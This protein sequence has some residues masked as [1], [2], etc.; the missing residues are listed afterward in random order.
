MKYTQT[1]MSKAVDREIIVRVA[2][3]FDHWRVLQYWEVGTIGVRSAA[4]QKA[5]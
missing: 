3:I 2:K 1:S 4:A 5:A